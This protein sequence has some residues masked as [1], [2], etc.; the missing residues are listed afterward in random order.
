MN[1]LLWKKPPSKLCISRSEIHVWKECL[2]TGFKKNKG[3]LTILSEEE[4]KRLRLFKFEKDCFRY[5]MTHG[6]KRLVLARY[7]NELP[8]KLSFTLSEQGKPAISEQQNRLNI[9]FNIS[10]SHQL[11]LMALTLE[12]PIGIDLEYHAD[13]IDVEN[14]SE[15]IFSPSEKCFFSRL[16]TQQERK[17][18][19]FRCWTRKEAYLKAEGIGLMNFSSNISV[20]MNEKPADDWLETLTMNKKKS[21]PWRLFPLNVNKLYTASIVSSTYQKHLIGYID[22]Y[23]RW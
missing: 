13:S 10:H 14:L 6:M 11:I 9:Q 22:P 5:T 7:L 19:F 23:G 17:K 20:D 8:E 18:A 12:D 16:A 1:K 2:S 15:I 21:L 4:N 3:R